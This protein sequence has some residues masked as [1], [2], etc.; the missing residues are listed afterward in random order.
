MSPPAVVA[1]LVSATAYATAIRCGRTERFRYILPFGIDKVA[2][3]AADMP[4]VL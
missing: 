1:M 3:A 4:D 2:A